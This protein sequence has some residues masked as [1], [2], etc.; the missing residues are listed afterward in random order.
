MDF[1]FSIALY[2]IVPADATSPQRIAKDFMRFQAHRSIH[3]QLTAAAVSGISH[4][5]Q[6]ETS[7]DFSSSDHGIHE[8]V[9]HLLYHLQDNKGN[10]VGILSGESGEL[11]IKF[12]KEYLAVM[13]REYPELLKP[14]VPED[15]AMNHL[16]GSFAETVKWWIA[17]K[18]KMPPEELA[19]YYLRLIG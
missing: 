15:L 4:D 13:F 14:D 5:L 17:Q 12:F 16:V 3:R 9:T 6:S 8:K 18:M 2:N 10:L 7:H 1:Y 19:D 11:F